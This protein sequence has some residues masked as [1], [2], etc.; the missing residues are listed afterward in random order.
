[1]KR[2]L[3]VLKV[4]T[5]LL[6]LPFV[7]VGYV[8]AAIFGLVYLNLPGTKRKAAERYDE[9]K[10]HIRTKWVADEKYLYVH[11]F[12]GKLADFVHTTVI[13]RYKEHIIVDRYDSQAKKWVSDYSDEEKRDDSIAWGIFGD[14]GH[15]DIIV[16]GLLRKTSFLD[17]ESYLSFERKVRDKEDFFKSPQGREYSREAAE[18]EIVI[19]IERT[20]DEWGCR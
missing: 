11:C 3:T 17:E 7:I 12:D 14:D 20:L 13:P 16:V 15:A 4:I 9:L 10:E 6:L 18:K 5:G 19:Y 1:M 2:I 8:I